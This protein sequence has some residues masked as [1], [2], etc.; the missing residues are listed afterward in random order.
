MFINNVSQTSAYPWATDCSPHV[1]ALL[2]ILLTKIARLQDDLESSIH[3]A[4]YW[5]KLEGLRSYARM[6]TGKIGILE[7]Y[8]YSIVTH[9]LV[10]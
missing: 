1:A 9:S 7:D 3:Y 4:L 8:N 5:A 6:D 10:V 2:C